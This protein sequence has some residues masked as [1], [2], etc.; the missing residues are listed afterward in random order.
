[1]RLHLAL[2][3]KEY[4]E[5]YEKNKELEPIKYMTSVECVLFLEGIMQKLSGEFKPMID[6]YKI[7]EEK[8]K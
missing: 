2:A 3:H 6:W 1:M 5:R 4:W 7:M 8:Y